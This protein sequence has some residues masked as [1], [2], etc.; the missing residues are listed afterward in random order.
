[1]SNNSEDRRED[2]AFY[3]RCH[4]C[5]GV[6]ADNEPILECTQCGHQMAPFFYFDVKK[7]RI[8]ADGLSSLGADSST[9]G[10]RPIEGLTAFW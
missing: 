9:E 6:C 3:R 2:Y 7:T 8:Y 4:V 10:F 1:M 5:N